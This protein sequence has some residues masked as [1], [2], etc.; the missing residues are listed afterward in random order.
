M[1][2]LQNASYSESPAYQRWEL[3]LPTNHKNCSSKCGF[4]ESDPPIHRA[5]RWNDSIQKLLRSKGIKD[6]LGAFVLNVLA[7]N[8]DAKAAVILL[9]LCAR[10]GWDSSTTKDWLNGSLSRGV[11]D[12]HNDAQLNGALQLLAAVAALNENELLVAMC[13][14]S[15]DDLSAGFTE[16]VKLSCRSGG[17]YTLRMLVNKFLDILK[18]G[19]ETGA[20]CRLVDSIGAKV[21]LALDSTVRWK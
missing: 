13:A 1:Y 10:I 5:C 7:N 21:E 11:A 19:N 20:A 3:H 2:I 18:T 6:P 17:K 9:D 8:L 16:S 15:I 4:H 14:H 12:K